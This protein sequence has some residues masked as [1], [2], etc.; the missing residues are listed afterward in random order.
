MIKVIL[1]IGD[2]EIGNI[3]SYAENRHLSESLKSEQSGTMSDEF[4]FDINWRKFKDFAATRFDDDP[5][6]LLRVGKTRVV[7]E[8]DGKVRFAGWLASRPARS[9]YGADQVLS[10][11][12]FEYFARLSGDIVTNPNDKKSPMRVFNNRPGH[13]YVQDLI[14]EFKA[15]AAA[16]GEVLNW[17]FGTVQTLANKTI[18]YK[19]FQTV[20]KALSDA[21]DN[22]Q[23]TGKFDV[24]FRTDPLDYTHQ[25]IDILAPRGTD[26]NI[27]IKYPS[28]G[29]YALWST[30]YSVEETND[31]ASEVIVSGNG[32][33]GDPAA[34]ENTAAIGTAAN[35]DFASEYCYWRTY[36][37]QSNLQSETAVQS[38]ANKL[39]T[40]RDFGLQV[41]K[42]TMVGRPIAWGVPEDEDKGLAIGDSFY[43]QETN[44]DGTDQSGQVRIIGLETDYDKNGVATVTPTLI[45]KA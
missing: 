41:P 26:K 24:V 14:D 20:S 7:L 10:L 18:T 27:I 13:L 9:G 30:D 40:E 32:Q 19:D 25:L 31:Y 29:V 15:R 35:N 39:L 6:S 2:T 21:M 34:G 17:S 4:T 45:R 23:G 11:K 42:I 5:A 8:I 36:D 43:F 12:F 37:P 28:D 33:V 22:T 44:D 1:Y 16:A 3:N 38:Y